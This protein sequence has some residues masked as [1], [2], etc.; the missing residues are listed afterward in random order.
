[1]LN[2][3]KEAAVMEEKSDVRHFCLPSLFPIYSIDFSD[4]VM[5]IFSNL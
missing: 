1:M 5:L 2:R 3:I 4:S